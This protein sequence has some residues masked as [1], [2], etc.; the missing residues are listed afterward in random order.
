MACPTLAESSQVFHSRN[1]RRRS[2][3]RE[4]PVVR[5]LPSQTIP[6]VRG[7][8][9]YSGSASCKS[10]FACRSSLPPRFPGLRPTAFLGM[11]NLRSSA[12]CNYS[13]STA[14]HR[15]IATHTKSKSKRQEWCV[16]PSH[17]NHA[18]P[19]TPLTKS[20]AGAWRLFR[21]E[22]HHAY[23]ANLHLAALAAAVARLAVLGLL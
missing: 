18:A 6:L 14:V 20:Q 22:H 1:L 19:V 12:E 15:R 10:D 11:V 13:A 16:L 9:S 5:G 8:N 4:I 3:C 21:S 23:S 7:N 2:A 17:F